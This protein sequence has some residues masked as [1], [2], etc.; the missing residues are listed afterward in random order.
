MVMFTLNYVDTVSCFQCFA[1]QSV[2][3]KVDPRR[4]LPIAMSLSVVP[5]QTEEICTREVQKM[6]LQPCNEMV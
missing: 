3:F 6:F 1:F 4:G 2:S 5:V